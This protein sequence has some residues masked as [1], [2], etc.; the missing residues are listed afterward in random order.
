MEA[1]S[2]YPKPN[3]LSGSDFKSFGTIKSALAVALLFSII[4]LGLCACLGL[5]ILDC[6]RRMKF[7]YEF[8]PP[9]PPE[10]G[11]KWDFI[12]PRRHVRQT[13]RR[14]SGSGKNKAAYKAKA[15][16]DRGGSFGM[17]VKPSLPIDE[18]GGDGHASSGGGVVGLAVIK[19]PSL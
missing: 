13:G 4:A 1:E 10:Y 2:F 12:S 18:E 11:W 7:L 19:A 8:H 14:A 9:P 16:R 5:Y 17:P 3:L 15:R 6:R